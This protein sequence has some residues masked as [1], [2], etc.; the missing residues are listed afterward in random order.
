MTVGTHDGRFSMT[1][2][3]REVEPPFHRRSV[4]LT[5]AVFVALVMVAVSGRDW[6]RGT[7]TMNTATLR[8]PEDSR[9]PPEQ[10]DPAE[11]RIEVSVERSWPPPLLQI[12]LNAA[13]RRE[14]SLL[15]GVGP[16]LAR[17]I[18]ADRGRNGPFH[19][20]EDLSR[21]HGIGPKTI[22]EIRSMCV[23]GAS[24]RG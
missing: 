8:L 22:F 18:L 16:V 20:V 14:L 9:R 4:Q 13:S 17:R 19:S 10:D 11:T 21:V 24:S 3:R 6:F 2:Q 1:E 23:V 12:D 7:S 5:V 15:P